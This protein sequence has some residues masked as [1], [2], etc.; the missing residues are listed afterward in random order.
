MAKRNK[1]KS[2]TN[3]ILGIFSILILLGCVYVYFFVLNEPSVDTMKVS[4]YYDADGNPI[5]SSGVK[6]AVLGGVEGVT[7]ITI[8]INALNKDTVSLDFEILNAT[9]EALSNVLTL[10]SKKSAGPNEKVT[11]TSGL[12][13]ITPYVGKTQVFTVT[14]QA[15][16]PIRTSLSKSASLSIAVSA[17]PVAGFDIS[18]EDNVGTGDFVPVPSEYCGDGTC[19]TGE[20]SDTCPDD[21]D[22]TT[23]PSSGNVIFRTTDL[24]YAIGSAIAYSS[25]C[26]NVLTSYGYASSYSTYYGN[27]QAT[28]ASR[29]ATC[30]T[31]TKVMDIPG[32]W[33]AGS[34]GTELWSCSG[35]SNLVVCDTTCV[36]SV[37]C[38]ANVDKSAIKTYSLSDTDATKVATISTSLELIKEV[39]C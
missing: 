31:A 20:T 35:T 10:S 30:G 16:S 13:D 25:S 8:D 26:G 4:G 27:C 6:Q 33:L 23:T 18:L 15:S 29:Y 1:K 5:S 2:S 11:W 19:Q 38:V 34:A 12:I 21:C 22:A 36:S 9:P 39:T 24:T 32:T 14:L 7:Y 37:S 3:I 17:D 28:I